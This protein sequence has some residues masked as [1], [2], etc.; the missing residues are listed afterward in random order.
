M[1]VLLLSPTHVVE[2]AVTAFG[3]TC[4]GHPDLAEFGQFFLTEFGQTAFGQLFV[5]G[6][7]PE[8]WGPGGVGAQTHGVLSQDPCACAHTTHHTLAPTTPP[9]FSFGKI[10]LRLF[11]SL[12]VCSQSTPSF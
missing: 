3:Q 7:G 12:L 4:F 6:G 10:W 11:V 8:G 1:E 9:A 2:S 5:F